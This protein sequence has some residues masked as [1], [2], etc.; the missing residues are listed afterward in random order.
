MG[1]RSNRVEQNSP[2][3]RVRSF[4]GFEPMSPRSTIPSVLLPSPGPDDRGY[5][6][7]KKPNNIQVTMS[8]NL[9]SLRHYYDGKL[10][11]CNCT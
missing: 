11:W 9:F 3:V 2:T 6:E 5:K 1:R 8:K 4:G 7:F 10:S